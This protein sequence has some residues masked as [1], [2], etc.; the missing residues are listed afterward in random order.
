VGYPRNLRLKINSD[1]PG[2]KLSK[3]RVEGH[4]TL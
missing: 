1:A 4:F 3:V 2:V